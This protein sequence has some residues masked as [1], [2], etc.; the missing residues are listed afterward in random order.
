MII[1][2]YVYKNIYYYSKMSTNNQYTIGYS[3]NDFFYVNVQDVPTDGSCTTLLSN[4]EWDMK[5]NN[6][7]FQDN[8][9]N[10]I[11]YAL[12]KN[13]SL[14]KTLQS[15]QG[16]DNGASGKYLDSTLIFNSTV[17]NTANL[18]IGIIV[19]IYLI[20]KNRIPT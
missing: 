19:L 5:C 10:C 7:S 16:T 4:T 13:K 2:E 14:A 15:Y 20:Y 11:N 17:L 9:T 12:C 3:H 1:T 6:E 8:S 18:S